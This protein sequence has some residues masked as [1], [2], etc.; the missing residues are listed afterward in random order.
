MPSQISHCGQMINGLDH[1]RVRRQKDTCIRNEYGE[2]RI[3][4]R[5]TRNLGIYVFDMELRQVKTPPLVNPCTVRRVM[6]LTFVMM[7]LCLLK[8]NND[9]HLFSRHHNVVIFD[10][11]KGIKS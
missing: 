8:L 3:E 5:N 10:T 2:Q 7:Q 4:I 9:H 6:V 1:D 11:S